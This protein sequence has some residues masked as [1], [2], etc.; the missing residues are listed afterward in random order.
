MLIPLNQFLHNCNQ[1]QNSQKITVKRLIKSISRV[2]C[3]PGDNLK[4]LL[5]VTKAT[6]KNINHISFIVEEILLRGLTIFLIQKVVQLT[7]T[8]I[9][10]FFGKVSVNSQMSVNFRISKMSYFW[11]KIRFYLDFVAKGSSLN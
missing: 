2:D 5:T 10:A 4:M 3:K 7:D 11:S 8:P 1:P 9:F 6:L